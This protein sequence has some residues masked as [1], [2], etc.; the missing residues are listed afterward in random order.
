MSK[1]LLLIGAIFMTETNQKFSKVSEIT[2]VEG[3][4]VGNQEFE[5]ADN[6]EVEAI[7]KKLIEQ[8]LEAY[9]KL[10]E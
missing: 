8:N 5:I 7:S 9:K 1:I 10:G 3:Y 6:E 4:T 2:S